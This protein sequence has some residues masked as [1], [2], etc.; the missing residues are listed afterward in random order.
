MG[1]GRG[2]SKGK[3]HKRFQEQ[4]TNCAKAAKINSDAQLGTEQ[5][6][7][8][9]GDKN[10][11]TG[12]PLDIAGMVS[13]FERGEINQNYAECL[14]NPKKP[15]TVADTRSLKVQVDWLAMEERA[16][17]TR[18][19]TIIRSHLHA[20]ARRAGHGHDKGVFMQGVLKYVQ[21][22]IKRGG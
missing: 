2:T 13:A 1:K 7:W 3:V 4:V 11:W 22:S 5:R 17:R 6:I 18:H 15:G 9:N 21:D 16:F 8:E 10:E 19:S 20:A 14:N 12:D